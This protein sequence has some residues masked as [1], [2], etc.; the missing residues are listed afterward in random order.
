MSATGMPSK[1]QH[2]T[3]VCKHCEKVIMLTRRSLTHPRPV[4]YDVCRMC[5]PLKGWNHHDA[6]L[7][8]SGRWT[9]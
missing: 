7:A 8:T 9:A 5:G 2:Y 3:L 1:R 4:K 6:P